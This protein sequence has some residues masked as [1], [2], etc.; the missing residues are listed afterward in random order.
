MRHAENFIRAKVLVRSALIPLHFYGN[1]Q[2]LALIPAWPIVPNPFRISYLAAL[3]PQLPHYNGLWNLPAYGLA[4]L[5]SPLSMF[6]WSEYYNNLFDDSLTRYTR[7][8]I[9]RPDN[10][11]NVSVKIHTE[12]GITTSTSPVDEY[13]RLQGSLGN[14]IRKDLAKCLESLYVAR[15]VARQFVRTL[16]RGKRPTVEFPERIVETEHDARGLDVP[17]RIEGTSSLSPS[18]REAF[19]RTANVAGPPSQVNGQHGSAPPPP[20]SVTSSA[21]SDEGSPIIQPSNV[22][23]RTRTGSTSTLHMEV[24]INT[25]VR[26]A[27]FTS[28]FSA[29]SRNMEM[30]N[31]PSQVAHDFHYRVT[32]LTLAP[33]CMLGARI[34]DT[35]VTVLGLPLESMFLRSLAHTFVQSGPTSR[36]TAWL[37]AQ[38]YPV[39]VYYFLG[40]KTLGIAALAT[41][42]GK[43]ILCIGIET[44][45]SL[46]LWHVTSDT[47]RWIG[48]RY[49]SWRKL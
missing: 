48:R 18:P 8:A 34:R 33:S 37:Q 1:L 19:D 38:I 7:A 29:S 22:Q 4:I 46:R 6:L 21:V 13:P 10:P 41:Y 31:M 2:Q 28:N 3:L 42:F 26:G 23:I 36:E 12:D 9:P 15:A 40:P 49:Y 14:E 25:Q 20:T 39:G 44:F 35:I 16:F 5:T 43:I 17:N 47:A 27:P 24:E 45:L 30:D 32:S 11:D